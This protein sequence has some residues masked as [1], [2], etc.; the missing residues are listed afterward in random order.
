[1]LDKPLPP[2]ARWHTEDWEGSIVYYDELLAVEDPAAALLGYA[3][4]VFAAA[5]PTLTDDAIT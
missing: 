1:L 3:G 5:S 4:A 2:P